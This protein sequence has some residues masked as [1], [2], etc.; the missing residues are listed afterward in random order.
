MAY[1]QSCLKLL[2]ITTRR[3]TPRVA[4]L[5]KP[6]LKKQQTTTSFPSSK[7]LP[8][9]V[10]VVIK[11]HSSG[12]PWIS[13]LLGKHGQ[14]DYTSETQRVSPGPGESLLL[15]ITPKKQIWEMGN[16][17]GLWGC[18]NDHKKIGVKKQERT[19][20]NKTLKNYTDEQLLKAPV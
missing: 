15:S 19:L 3:M 16:F 5:S 7:T 4:P 20:R 14:L 1:Q 9:G 13:K 8:G 12:T 17:H 11:E 2:A 6:S 18:A 10:S